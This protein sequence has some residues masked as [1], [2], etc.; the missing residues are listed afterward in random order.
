MFWCILQGGKKHPVSRSSFL[1]HPYLLPPTCNSPEIFTSHCHGERGTHEF[2]CMLGFLFIKIEMT[3][4]GLL[5]YMKPCPPLSESI[6]PWNKSYWRNTEQAFSEVPSAVPKLFLSIV[7][8]SQSRKW[9]F[10]HNLYN[11]LL[12]SDHSIFLRIPQFPKYKTLKDGV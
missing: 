5:I 2:K 6:P 12:K 3:N 9:C 10:F 4:K 7:F 11:A 8:F 1:P